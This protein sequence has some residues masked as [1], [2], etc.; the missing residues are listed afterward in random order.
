MSELLD[1]DYDNEIDEPQNVLVSTAEL[2]SDVENNDED[3]APFVNL[4]NGS[5]DSNIKTA[6]R[7]YQWQKHDTSMADSMFQGTFPEP[8]EEELTP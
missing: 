1:D 8:K 6:N 3:D 4:A 7:V 2:S 5:S